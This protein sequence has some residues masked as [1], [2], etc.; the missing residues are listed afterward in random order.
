MLLSS[1]AATFVVALGMWPASAAATATGSYADTADLYTPAGAAVAALV[2][3]DPARAVAVLPADFEAE[4]G[5]R[6]ELIDGTPTDPAGDCSS[7]I[8]LPDRFEHPCKVHDFGY[9]LLRLAARHGTPLGGWARVALDRMLAQEMHRTCSNPICDWA[10]DLA[11][12]GV[13]F[14][15]WRQR[16]RAPGATESTTAIVASSFV[17]GG[18][19]IAA[20]VGLR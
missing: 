20:L 1:L 7:P 6:P 5:Y 2:G 15:T 14:N 11:H 12:T 8:P 10:A 3:P 16:E 18:E 4:M 17:R 13:A 19:E 9:D